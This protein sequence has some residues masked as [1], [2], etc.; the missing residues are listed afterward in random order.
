M[1]TDGGL[2]DT[3]VINN[4][5]IE[6]DGEDEEESDEDVVV[7]IGEIKASSA[8]PK[9]S[10]A[11]TGK[12]ELDVNPAYKGTTIYDLDLASM[13]EKPWRK[14]GADI[15][16]YFNYGFN[17]G[18]LVYITYLNLHIEFCICCGRF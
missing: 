14:P 12:I 7:T 8:Y 6:E 1:E 17:E 13:E 15:T 11:S 18:N 9:S 2:S 16:D 3:I 5:P 4:T 10:Y